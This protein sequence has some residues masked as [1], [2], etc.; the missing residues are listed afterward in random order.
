MP[1]EPMPY[2]WDQETTESLADM[3]QAVYGHISNE[4]DNGPGWVVVRGP[5]AWDIEVA[6][7]LRKKPPRQQAKLYGSGT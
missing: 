1:R 2:T 4:L 6:I 3:K 5:D 7:M